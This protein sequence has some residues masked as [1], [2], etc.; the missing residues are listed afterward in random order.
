MKNREA[1]RF[2]EDYR[3]ATGLGA[4][5]ARTRTYEWAVNIQLRAGGNRTIELLSDAQTYLR[6][7]LAQRH[8]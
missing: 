7:L 8:T 1:L 5:L 4:A 6:E 3:R 2:V